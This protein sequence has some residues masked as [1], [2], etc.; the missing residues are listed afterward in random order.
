MIDS[1]YTRAF[2]DWMACAVAG[3]SEPAALA[4][5]TVGDGVADRVATLSAA[6]HVLDFDD[7]YGPGLSHLSA[8]TAPAALVVGADTG[9]TIGQVLDAYARGFEAMAAVA[10][11]SHPNLYERGWHPTAVTGTIGAATA[12]AALLA[13]D[14]ERTRTA[15]RLAVLGAGGLR[16]AFGTDGKAL[17]VGSAAAHGVRAAILAGSG[18]TATGII[19]SA[20]CRRLRGPVGRAGRAGRHSRQLDQGLSLLS[21]DS[22]GHRGGR[23]SGPPGRRY[24]SLRSRHRAPAFPAGGA[25]R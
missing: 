18:A 24:R 7:T 3:R 5:R 8:P 25:A 10:K 11:A 22:R 9:A 4:A 12:A 1:P 2:L 23:G 16:A 15:C 14:E 13:L 20:F 17:Q 21:A 6:G 19:E